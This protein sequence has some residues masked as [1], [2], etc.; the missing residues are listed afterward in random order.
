MKTLNI[1]TGNHQTITIMQ[2]ERLFERMRGLIKRT[3]DK[4]HVAGLWIIPCNAVHTIG[5]NYPLDLIYVDKNNTV[6]KVIK[7]IGQGQFSGA[8]K[9]HSVIEMYAGA[10]QDLDIKIGDTIHV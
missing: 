5:M 9:A 7:N 8:L 6:V 1:H 2:T 4:E 3:L 10:T